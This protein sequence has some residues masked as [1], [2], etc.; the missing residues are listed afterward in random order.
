MTNNNEAKDSDRARC[1]EYHV[2]P[3]NTRKTTVALCHSIKR[4]RTCVYERQLSKTSS[5]LVEKRKE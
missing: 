1:T 3:E 4:H 2:T 5:S